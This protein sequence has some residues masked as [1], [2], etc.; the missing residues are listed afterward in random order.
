MERSEGT[1]F[2]SV[3]THH[4]SITFKV[5]LLHFFSDPFALKRNVA[6]SLNSQMVFE[7]VQERFRTA[8]KYFACPQSKDR[9]TVEHQRGKD[10]TKHGG[11]K[12][13][14]DGRKGGEEGSE[15]SGGGQGD[16]N[17]GKSQ[18][19]ETGPKE[20]G[21]S[22][23]GER[24]ER[25]QE[26]EE[27]ALNG[28]LMDLVLSGGTS[29]DGAGAEPGTTLEPSSASTHNGLLDRDEEEENHVSEKQG[30]IAPED[31]HY[32]FDRMIFTGGKVPVQN[33]F[34]IVLNWITKILD[35]L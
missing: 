15:K 7:Y 10:T 9:N 26:E 34:L 4:C 14:E 8:Y 24:A 30:H 29:T 25:A 3:S 33:A 23:E 12:Q 32:I 31:L 11:M 27:R 28:G 1:F 2:P 18:S 17:E 19:S 21:E 20:D 35:L 5:I 13:E 22:D 16:G 6:R